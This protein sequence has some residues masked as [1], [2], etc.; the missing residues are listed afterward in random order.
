MAIG[1]TTT[2][3]S[4]RVLQRGGSNWLGGNIDRDCQPTGMALHCKD[5]GVPYQAF[6]NGGERAALARPVRRRQR[7][8]WYVPA[9][10]RVAPFA[11]WLT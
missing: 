4:L 2:A 11:K 6:Q 3:C 5:A 1:N 8:R 9:G 7:Q 10:Q